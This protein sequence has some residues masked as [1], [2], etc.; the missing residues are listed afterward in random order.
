MHLISFIFFSF[1]SLKK[2]KKQKKLAE[3]ILNV[4]STVIDSDS[5]EEIGSDFF[6]DDYENGDNETQQIHK[7]SEKNLKK[8][9]S[10]HSSDEDEDED[11]EDKK[12]K[13]YKRIKKSIL[14]FL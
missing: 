3:N 8:E 14:I 2:N 7:L 9:P 4:S 1:R 10:P 11:K 6:D 5:S 13:Y 12:N